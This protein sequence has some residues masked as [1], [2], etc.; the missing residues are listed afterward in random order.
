MQ[1]RLGHRLPHGPAKLHDDRLLALLQGVE[2]AQEHEEERHHDDDDRSL[3]HCTHGYLPSAN[4]FAPD[5][6]ESQGTRAFWSLSTIYSPFISAMKAAQGFQVQAPARDLR[7]LV[8]LVQDGLK[9]GRLAIG[10]VDPLDGVA[11]GLAQAPRGHAAGFGDFR[12]LLLGLID[13]PFGPAAT[14]SPR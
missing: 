12:D 10:P 14:R 7:G 9:A 3:Q 2:R 4:G 11:F 1:S 13:R 8:I 5:S 6:S